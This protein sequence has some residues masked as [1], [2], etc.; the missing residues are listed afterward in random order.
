MAGSAA[1]PTGRPGS[2]GSRVSKKSASA[3]SS[4]KKLLKEDKNHGA[5]EDEESVNT[6]SSHEDDKTIESKAS[7][8]DRSHRSNKSAMKF[9]ERSDKKIKPDFSYKYKGTQKKDDRTTLWLANFEGRIEEFIFPSLQRADGLTSGAPAAVAA[10]QRRGFDEGG[11]GQ[12]STNA[13]FSSRIKFP[14]WTRLVKEHIAEEK[15]LDRKGSPTSH[16]KADFAKELA[17]GEKFLRDKILL[18]HKRGSS[19][20]DVETGEKHQSGFAF[21]KA[22]SNELTRAIGLRGDTAALLEPGHEVVSMFYSL[23][24]D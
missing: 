24:I 21:L 5:N 1:N 20:W 2:R 7:T 10:N 3:E 18:N 11:P 19:K 12:G 13:S 22:P 15:D 14:K 4:K 23:K 16:R 17:T 9:K 8:A 6:A